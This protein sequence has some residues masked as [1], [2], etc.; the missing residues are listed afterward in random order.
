MNNMMCLILIG[1]LA[2]EVYLV[3]TRKGKILIT[4]K[5]DFFIYS[6]ILLLAVLVLPVS[7]RDIVANIRNIL[8]LAVILGSVGIRR[9]FSERGME[10]V[11][12]V[13]P[14]EDIR[15]VRIHEYQTSKIQVVCQTGNGNFK[16]LLG[17]HKLKELT[18]ILNQYV[19]DIYLQRSL[20]K[21][22]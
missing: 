9:G 8:I 20:E 18:G 11:C 17:R 7:A 16:L 6:F 10:K 21:T 1:C 19:S 12:F 14:W 3:I 15:S 5:D 22:L 13:I 2:V 4:G